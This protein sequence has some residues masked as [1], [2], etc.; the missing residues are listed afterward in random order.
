MPSLS[1]R[2]GLGRSWEAKLCLALLLALL[3]TLGFLAY[4]LLR[5]PEPGAASA[6]AAPNVPRMFGDQAFAFL[7]SPPLPGAERNPF[8]FRRS[9]PKPQPQVRPGGEAGAAGGSGGTGGGE[10]RPPPPPPK[11][12]RTLLFSGWMEAADGARVAFVEIADARTNT[13]LHRGPVRVGDAV[14]GFEV[15]S[16]A[17]DVV[18]L[19]GPGGQEHDLPLRESRTVELP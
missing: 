6:Q 7:H 1:N 11:P 4:R 17:A 19:R 5:E 14:A 9:Y 16:V 2:P 8:R 18:R 13:P 10:S 12:R 3:V 15:L